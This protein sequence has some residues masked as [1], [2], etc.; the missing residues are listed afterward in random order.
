MI[1][2]FHS[3]ILP[4]IDDGAKDISMAREMLLAE[5]QSGVEAIVATP[6]FYLSE[7]SVE[8]FLEKR[9]NAFNLIK[10]EADRLGIEIFKGASVFLLLHS[11]PRSSIFPLL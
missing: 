11:S 4:G 8:S 2:D 10:P 7:E 3:H 6:H 5:E 9:E 1:V